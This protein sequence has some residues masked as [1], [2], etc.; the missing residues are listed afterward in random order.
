MSEH[1]H[2][3]SASELVGYTTVGD[4]L[5]RYAGPFFSTRSSFD[6]FVKRNRDELVEVGALIPR[7]GRS[8]SLVSVDRMPKAV[9]Q[10]LRRKA[11]DAQRSA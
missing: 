5:D 8:G 2:T 9:I 1:Q 6:W 10:I 7:H 4:W 3:G 11:L